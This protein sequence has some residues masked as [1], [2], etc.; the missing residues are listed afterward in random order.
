M[1]W[2]VDLGYITQQITRYPSPI[3]HDYDK[4]YFRIVKGEIHTIRGRVGDG[5]RV[6]QLEHKGID[7]KFKGWYTGP[8]EHIFTMSFLRNSYK[9][10][11]T[12]GP[13]RM[14]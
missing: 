10:H 6:N 2:Y 14:D 4:T 13:T 9:G 3:I 7:A 12:Y 8:T 11:P 1:V 5:K